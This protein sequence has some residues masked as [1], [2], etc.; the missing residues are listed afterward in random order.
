MQ[1]YILLKEL[2]RDPT[3]YLI[4]VDVTAAEVEKPSNTVPVNPSPS[5]ELC[6]LQDMAAD[7]CRAAIKKSGHIWDNEITVVSAADAREV[8][9]GRLFRDEDILKLSLSFFAIQN[10]FEFMVERSD[11]K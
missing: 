7:I 6:T 8:E 2:H 11:K 3:E 10:M 4:I 5:G 9:E 1:S